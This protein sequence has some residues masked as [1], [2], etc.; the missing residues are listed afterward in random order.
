V[1]LTDFLCN[2]SLKKKKC[3]LLLYVLCPAVIILTE[4]F[5]KGFIVLVFYYTLYRFMFQCCYSFV[6]LSIW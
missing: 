6:A 4:M 2:K 3:E 5:S 1:Y